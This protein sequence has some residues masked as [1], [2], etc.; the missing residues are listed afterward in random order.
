MLLRLAELASLACAAC[1]FAASRSVLS[2]ASACNL[3][4]K[5]KDAVVGSV[6]AASGLKLECLRMASKTGAEQ[7]VVDK[8]PT[9]KDDKNFGFE[10]YDNYS[11]LGMLNMKCHEDQLERKTKGKV[12]SIIGNVTWLG[13]H[14]PLDKDWCKLYLMGRGFGE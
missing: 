14:E 9:K 8:M 7:Y 4:F 12:S 11:A 1:R 3:T 5:G 6:L 2:E 13:S 10:G